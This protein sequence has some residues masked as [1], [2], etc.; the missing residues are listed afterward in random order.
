MS[1]GAHGVYDFMMLREGGRLS[2]ARKSDLR[3]PT[4]F[5]QLTGEGRRCVSINMPLDQDSIDGAVIVNSWLTDDPE[6]RILP[7]DR[8]DPY[9]G[10]LDAYEVFPEDPG[11]VDELCRLEQSRF[12]LARELF[13]RESWDHFFVLFSSTDWLGH[14]VTGAFL[15]GDGAARSSFLRLYR[16][17]DDYVGWLVEHAP[18]ALVVLSD[19]GQ[20]QEQA[21]VRVNTILRG[22][23]LVK[24]LERKPEEQ[25]PFFVGRRATRR[26]V[27]VP[28][29]VSRFRF[30]RAVRPVAVSAKRALR[31]LGVNLT[32]AS[33]QVDRARSRAFSPTDS[34]FAIHA[35][36]AGD[37]DL[38]RIRGALLDVRLPDGRLAFDG[39]W[40]H[41]ELYGCAPGP[42]DPLLVFSPALGV[43]PSAMLKE[44]SVHL[45][46][47]TAR[48]CH[49]RDGI[50]LVRGAPIAAGTDLG[51]PSIC[52]IAPTLLWAM[53]AGVPADS[54]GRVLF[55]AFDRGFAESRPL[56]E[57]EV[58]TERRAAADDD[59][60]SS[61]VT[62]RL[63]AL[64]YI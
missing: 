1:P 14:G 34:S 62:D 9:R 13:L 55:E 16:Q 51:H 39:V 56:V 18:D 12:A 35:A 24:A 38:D 22:L 43:R 8:L 4:Y 54:D 15:E 19:H 50:V 3:R 21:V 52:D 33:A 30:N 42:G 46:K 45:Q 29:W 20:C 41:E 53:E 25:D 47:A 36:D 6:R 48:G 32:S 7:P 10:L 5:D 57:V 44:P 28:M 26:T 58:S 37:E 63:K 60:V 40:S 11:D 17:L 27:K 59:D 64:G 23:G 31:R 2:V 61:E 49:Q